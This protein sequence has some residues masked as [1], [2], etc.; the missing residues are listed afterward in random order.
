MLTRISFMPQARVLA[1]DPFPSTVVISITD[2]SP[3]AVRPTLAGFLDVLRLEF[4]D[5]AEEQFCVAAGAWPPEP[6]SEEHE[7]FSGLLGERIPTLSDAIAIRAF[8]DKHHNKPEPV[9]VV[10]HCFAGASR[11]AAVAKWAGTVYD[12][13]I[14][15]VERRGT[16]EANE[17]LLRLLGQTTPC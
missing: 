16:E 6:T 11:S 9:A 15:D 12:V 5:V 7:K 10:V 2:S 1:L 4:V 17:R 8:L 13:P 14:D 3:Y